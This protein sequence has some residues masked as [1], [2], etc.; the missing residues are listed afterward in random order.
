MCK[1]CQPQSSVCVCE[2]EGDA[3][4]AGLGDRRPPFS[5]R[6]HGVRCLRGAVHP[7]GRQGVL[8]V[9]PGDLWGHRNTSIIISMRSVCASVL[10]NPSARGQEETR[11]VLEKGL[12]K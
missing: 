11:T 7:G 6:L 12:V 5:I 2:G 3:V 10:S 8:V 1:A 9:V 4:R